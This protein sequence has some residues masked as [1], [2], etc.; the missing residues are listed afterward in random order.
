V[1]R[2]NLS[3]SKQARL[4]KLKIQWDQLD[5]RDLEGIKKFL[6]EVIQLDLMGE[7]ALLLFKEDETF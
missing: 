2:E 1:E 3:E 5:R 7:F 4:S 6:D